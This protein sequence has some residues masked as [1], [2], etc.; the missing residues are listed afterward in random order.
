MFII[1]E[2]LWKSYH[3][4]DVATEVLKGIHLSA[5]QGETC[6]ILGPSGSGKTTLLNILG[7]IDR[8]DKGRVVVDGTDVTA[9]DDDA[10]TEYRREKIGFI[11]QFYNLIPNLSVGENIEV[12]A[13]ISKSPL[14][15]DD[16]LRAVGLPDKKHRFPRELSGGEQQRV[17]IARAVVKNPK[18]LLCDEL[19]GALDYAASREILKLMQRVSREFGTTVFIITHNSAIAAMASRVFTLRSG[20]I[21]KETR[22]ETPLPAERIEW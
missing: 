20:E 11:F 8:A 6:V 16:V 14:K 21:V 22:S 12:V 10:L 18:L 17:S 7:G 15:T 4:G 5:Q 13:N 2:N 9:L 3:S 19:T 1:V